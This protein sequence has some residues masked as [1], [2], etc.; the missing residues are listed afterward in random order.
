M[1]KEV[2]YEEALSQLESIAARIESG[3]LGI[4]LLATELKNAQKLV[5]LCRDRLTKTDEEIRK[6][7]GGGEGE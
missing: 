3:D 4:D 2:K 5:K 7:L 6:L 1:G